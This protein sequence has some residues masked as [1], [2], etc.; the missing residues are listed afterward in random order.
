VSKRDGRTEP[1]DSD[2]L[3]RVLGR[4]CRGRKNLQ[5]RDLERVA[6]GIEAELLDQ[7]VRSISTAELIQRLL[8][9]LSDL[10]R[11]AYDRLAADYV[12]EDGNLRIA[13]AQSDDEGDAG[14]L[15]LFPDDDK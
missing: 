13:P 8:A 11:V 12:D 10:D 2:K 6:R 15:G 5:A 7:H 4:V 14:Q 1:F 9:K 3:L